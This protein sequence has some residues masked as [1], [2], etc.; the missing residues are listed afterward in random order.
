MLY[1]LYSKV[2][3]WAKTNQKDIFLA[4]T[5]I[6]M[7]VISFGLG[8]LSMLVP[9]KKPVSVVEI[10]QNAHSSRNDTDSLTPNTVVTNSSVSSGLT[11]PS[12][13]GQYVGSKNSTYYHLPWC[14]GALRI[15]DENKIWFETKEEAESRGYVPAG[16]CKGL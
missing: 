14:P 12:A 1:T 4:A 6:L 5:I 7:S 16:N 2:N 10:G 8:R 13:S 11:P 9:E 3:R 15:K